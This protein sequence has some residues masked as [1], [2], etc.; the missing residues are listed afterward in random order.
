MRMRAQ[1]L[2]KQVLPVVVP[3]WCANDDVD[4]LTSRHV[5]GSQVTGA[6]WALV[7]ELDENDRAVDPVVEHRVVAHA[8]R[9]RVW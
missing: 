4:V 5:R 1:V 2:T 8:S 3:V 6:D 7:V 9:L